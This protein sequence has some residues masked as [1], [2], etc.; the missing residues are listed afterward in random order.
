MV[1]KAGPL[2]WVR[3]R[4][5]LYLTSYRIAMCAVIAQ[6]PSRHKFNVVSLRVGHLDPADRLRGIPKAFSMSMTSVSWPCLSESDLRAVARG[7][8]SDD[9]APGAGE[10][11][12]PAVEGF[13]PMG[14]GEHRRPDE[15]RPWR[16]GPREAEGGPGG[17]VLQLGE[18]ELDLAV[19]VR[20][21]VLRDRDGRD[22]G[23]AVRRR[24]RGVHI[25]PHGHLH[26]RLSGP[27]GSPD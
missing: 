19:G 9:P 7:A 23:S 11:R 12:R 13:R 2:V 5:G 15:T 25:R 16:G 1:R 20:H 26:P 8:E 18:T 22:L 10:H 6:R 4:S 17:R 3:L 21:H 14:R 24:Q 27:P